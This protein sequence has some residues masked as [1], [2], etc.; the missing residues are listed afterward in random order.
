MRIVLQR[1]SWA[2]VHVNG[3]EAGAIGPGLLALVG[4]ARGDTAEQ[5]G[6]LAAKT[7]RLRL[8][9]GPERPFDLPL[10]EV[11]GGGLLCVSQFTLLG[12]VRKGNRPSWSGAAPGEEAEPL[13]EAYAAAVAA[14]GVAVGRGRF[15]A[16]MDI[17][18]ENDGPV[19]LVLDG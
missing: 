6:R 8:F 7:V 5:A 15:G 17:S 10:T 18:L 16:H 3:E 9:D 13:V 4:A 12:D 2:R 11:P 14:H 1:V 19:T